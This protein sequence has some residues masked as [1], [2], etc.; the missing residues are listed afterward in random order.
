MRVQF[1]QFLYCV[2]LYRSNLI[3]THTHTFNS[4]VYRII[5]NLFYKLNFNSNLI[6][7]VY[8]LNWFHTHVRTYVH[9]QIWSLSLTRTFSVAGSN[10][11]THTH[12]HTIVHNTTAKWNRKKIEPNHTFNKNKSVTITTTTTTTACGNERMN[13]KWNAECGRVGSSQLASS[14]KRR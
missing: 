1:A 3:R 2:S 13:G 6:D 9:A 7:F 11:H 14:Q 5:G 8:L 10:R 12:T 4:I